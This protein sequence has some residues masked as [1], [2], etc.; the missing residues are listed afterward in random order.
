MNNKK[1]GKTGIVIM[2][3]L[4]LSSAGGS[5]IAGKRALS[6]ERAAQTEITRKQHEQRPTRKQRKT[7]A[8]AL[9]AK[10]LEVYRA[11]QAVQK[12]A[13]VTPVNN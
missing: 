1:L 6:P 3:T 5:A 11:K 7:A 8:E 13:P 12:S 4:L 10:R 9:K 2:M